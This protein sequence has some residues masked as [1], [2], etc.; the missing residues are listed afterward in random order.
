MTRR[1]QRIGNLLRLEI[2]DLLQHQMNDPRLSNF[3]SVTEVS[4]SPDLRHA[5][6]FVSVL[7][8]ETQKKEVLQGFAAA[9]GFIHRELANR[10]TLRRIPELS[11]HLDNSIEQGAKV[12]E[13]I[14][15]TTFKS[16][17]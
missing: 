6:V 5:K 8:N 13:L 12:L 15:K 14:E 1:T 9:T 17:E 4:T 7:G 10:L 3:I 2:S 16:Q 11:F